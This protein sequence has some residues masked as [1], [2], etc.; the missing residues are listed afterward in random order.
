MSGTKA[1]SIKARETI[2]KRHG[3]DFFKRIGSIGGSR[4]DTKPKG[5]AA[6]PE[7]ARKAGSKGGKRSTRK[8]IKNGEG[9][10]ER[11]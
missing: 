11:A 6:N 10:Y 4:V 2:L 5:F 7:L 9:R 3:A 8:G 1:G